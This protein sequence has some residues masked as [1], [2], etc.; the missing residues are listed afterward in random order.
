MAPP[1]KPEPGRDPG[2]AD[3]ARK[4][5]VVF[6]LTSIVMLVAF[7]VMIWADYDREWKKYQKAFNKLEVKVTEEQAQQ[8][9]DKVPGAQQQSLQGEMDRGK[10]EEAQRREAIKKAQA[11]KDKLE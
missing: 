2:M 11:E 6:A 1:P 9:K 3:R 7:T 4:L 5:N 10:Q 8:A